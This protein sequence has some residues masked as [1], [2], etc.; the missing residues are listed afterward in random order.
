MRKYS[1]SANWSD[2]EALLREQRIR[3]AV[4]SANCQQER[5]RANCDGG[6]PRGDEVVCATAFAALARV[7][8]ST[9]LKWK[10]SGLLPRPYMSTRR[11]IW[12]REDVM[13]ALARLPKRYGRA[14]GRRCN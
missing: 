3:R 4:E 13:A 10:A 5:F 2:S 7:G 6:R 12:H 1:R 9:F 11:H 8:M 14:S